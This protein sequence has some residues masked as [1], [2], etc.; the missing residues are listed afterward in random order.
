MTAREET[1]MKRFLAKWTLYTILAVNGFI[2]G[3]AYMAVERGG[4]ATL[5][6]GE[7]ELGAPEVV[8]FGVL[9]VFFLPFI[10]A[11]LSEGRP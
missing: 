10:F 4:M 1:G 5:V 3:L 8:N 6:I 7:L 2:I 9:G 11:V